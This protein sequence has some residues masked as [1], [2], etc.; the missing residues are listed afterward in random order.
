[1]VFQCK[2]AIS[3]LDL[4]VRCAFRDLQYIVIALPNEIETTTKQ[5]NIRKR[6]ENL[7]DLNWECYSENSKIC[8]TAL[9]LRWKK[10]RRI[11]GRRKEGSPSFDSPL[12]GD[13]ISALEFKGFGS[14]LQGLV[15]G[16]RVCMNL[17]GMKSKRIRVFFFLFEREISPSVICCCCNALSESTTEERPGSG[18]YLLSSGINSVLSEALEIAAPIASW[19]TSQIKS[20][21]HFFIYIFSHP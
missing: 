3:S 20:R 16:I 19:K 5:I 18:L 4:L 12:R 21:A 11:G 2:L 10:G 14:R 15:R 17:K 9:T 13:V 8:S 7:H 6:K 1:M